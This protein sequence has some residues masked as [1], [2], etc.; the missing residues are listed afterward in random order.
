MQSGTA[1]CHDETDP[2]GRAMLVSQQ[3]AGVQELS[4]SAGRSTDSNLP[5]RFVPFL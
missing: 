5:V 4:L 1:R 3:A 2:D